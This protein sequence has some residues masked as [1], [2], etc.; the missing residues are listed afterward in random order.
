MTNKKK[1]KKKKKKKNR[2]LQENITSVSD[3]ETKLKKTKKGCVLH[4]SLCITR[5][6]ICVRK[7]SHCKEEKEKQ[8]YIG[9]GLS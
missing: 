2:G 3:S 6:E 4:S 8:G 5:T 1:K 9:F 7:S